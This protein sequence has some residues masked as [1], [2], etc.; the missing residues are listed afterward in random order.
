MQPQADT[1]QDLVLSRSAVPDGVAVAPHQRR[2]RATPS[3][4]ATEYKPLGK[5]GAK[6]ADMQLHRLR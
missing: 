2:Y 5:A 1:A 3:G 4:T 6:V